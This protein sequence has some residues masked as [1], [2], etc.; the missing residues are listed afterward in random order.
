MHSTQKRILTAALGLILSATPLLTSA[1]QD[2]AGHGN[3]AGQTQQG[4]GN[5][6]HSGAGGGMNHGDGD[7]GGMNHGDG[8]G[9]G[10][11]NHGGGNGG[12]MMRRGMQRMGNAMAGGDGPATTGQS[13]FAVIRDVVNTLQAD[14]ETDWSRINIEALRQHLVDMDRVTLYAEA[15]ASEVEGGAR[16]RVTG[17]DERTVAA[18]QRMV[19]T[20]ALQIERELD[21]DT[22]TDTL[23]DG[24]ELT[25]TATAEEQTAMIRGL[26]FMGFMVQGEHHADHHLMMA[27]GSPQSSGGGSMGGR[28][29]GGMNHEEMQNGNRNG[30]GN[31]H[32]H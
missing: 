18:I 28:N 27:G 31:A 3:Q 13:A 11:M 30:Q 26:G 9:G 17:G 20:H 16:Y 19:P 5:G 2:H 8:N 25:V 22:S 29:Q 12:G 4:A 7:G 10:M 24:V 32:Q 14:P 23:R 1:Q 15:E 6:Q 21:W